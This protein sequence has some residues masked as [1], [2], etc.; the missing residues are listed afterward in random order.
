MKIKQAFILAA[1]LGKR[2][3]PITNNIP[4]P[5]VEVNG[6]SL[7]TRAIDQLKNAGIKKI[8]INS[9]HKADLLKQHI[10]SYIKQTNPGIKIDVIEEE[11]LLETGGGIVNALQ[12]MDKE[13]FFVVN[14]DSL[15]AGTEN[16]FTY[17]MQHWDSKMHSLFLLQKI[18][19]A[20][21]YDHTGD[22]DLDENNMLVRPT[23]YDKL[24]YAY[25]GIHITKPENF[26]ELKTE[27]RKL[28]DIYNKCKTKE[29]YQNIHGAIY[30][31]SW[32]HVGTADAIK[33]T[34]A[35]L[36]KLNETIPASK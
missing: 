28:M 25:A 9:F 2:M 22:F 26:A 27:K 19:E 36:A 13:A 1:G 15:W 3:Q 24:P 29:S 18:E 6:Q 17:L 4:K 11:E 8:V 7:I 12:H 32:F 20:I 21:G 23:E 31:G 16:A 10:A 5:M 14:G 34:E 30:N 35:L 33:N